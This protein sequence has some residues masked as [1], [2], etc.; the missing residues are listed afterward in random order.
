MPVCRVDLVTPADVVDRMI[1]VPQVTHVAEPLTDG[2]K[3]MPCAVMMCSERS[4][5]RRVVC[6]QNEQVCS[7]VLIVGR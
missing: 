5:D 3:S 7:V 4:V 1:A 6:S 2:L